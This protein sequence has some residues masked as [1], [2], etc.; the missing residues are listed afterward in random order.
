M[1]LFQRKPIA[2]LVDDIGGEQSLTALHRYAAAAERSYYKAHKELMANKSL[3][4][5]EPKL[6]PRTLAASASTSP[7]LDP[8][9]RISTPVQNEPN[10][11][12]KFINAREENLALRL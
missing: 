9:R 10:S 3:V 4:Q 11:N 12:L 7:D 6:A 5:N 1:Q 8:E 2:A